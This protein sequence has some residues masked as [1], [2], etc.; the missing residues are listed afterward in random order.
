MK[1]NRTNYSEMHKKVKNQTDPI[2]DNLDEM[3]DLEIPDELVEA[4]AEAIPNIKGKEGY[5]IGKIVNVRAEK[6]RESKI[7]KILKTGAPLIIE[8]EY[9]E[10]YKVITED[11]IIGFIQR[12]LVEVV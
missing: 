1:N 6:S 11:G 9:E 12:R 10:W 5:I 8:D 4:Y 2:L 7:L 3:G